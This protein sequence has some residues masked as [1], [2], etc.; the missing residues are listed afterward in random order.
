MA[1]TQKNNKKRFASQPRAGMVQA[2]TNNLMAIGLTGKPPRSKKKRGG[3]HA[4]LPNLPPVKI[5]PK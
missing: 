3:G 4:V 1:P 5:M 2:F